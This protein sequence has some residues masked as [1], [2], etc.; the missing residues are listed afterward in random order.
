[1]RATSSKPAASK[2]PGVTQNRVREVLAAVQYAH[3]NNLPTSD[4]RSAQGYDFDIGRTQID[5][6]EIPP[7]GFPADGGEQSGAGRQYF[8][9][10][11]GKAGAYPKHTSGYK[12]GGSRVI[13]VLDQTYTHPDEVGRMDAARV[14]QGVGV[15]HRAD[16]RVP[17][18]Q[19]Y[20][21]DHIEN[22]ARTDPGKIRRWD[23]RGSDPTKIWGPRDPNKQAKNKARYDRQKAAKEALKKRKEALG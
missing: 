17:L 12:G 13:G 1:V 19:E 20:I 15:G 4:I 5:P 18:E 3:Q 14:Q 23:H 11:G 10:S 9:A 6:F 2:S 22:T 8:W 16:V 21:K 7:K